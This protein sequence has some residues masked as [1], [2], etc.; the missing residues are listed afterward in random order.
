MG[1]QVR[2][3]CSDMLASMTRRTMMLA[4]LA[5]VLLLAAC[6]P[7]GTPTPSPTPSATP[8]PEALPAVSTQTTCRLLFGSNVDGPL[9]DAADLVTRAVES[10]DLSSAVTVEELETTI[11]S[12][13][14]A[15][16]NASDDLVPYISAQIAPLQ[17][18]V[19]GL[20]GGGGTLSLDFADFKASALEL[21][22]TCER[23]L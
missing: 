10:P 2:T 17:E 3:N 21:L 6:A 7:A 12:I 4:P 19:D 20:K 14:T 23:F 11:E 22:N 8:T 1:P 16:K 9:S 15:R 13:E 5:L 18:M